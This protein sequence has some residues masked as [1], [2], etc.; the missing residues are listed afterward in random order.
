MEYQVTCVCGNKFKVE[1]GDVGKHVACPACNRALIPVAAVAVGGAEGAAGAAAAAGAVAP[2]SA[3]AMEHTAMKRCPFCGEPILAIA[4][5][6]RYCK[7][8][9]DRGA[10]GAASGGEAAAGG[11]AGAGEEAAAVFELSVSQW[12]NFF[13]YVICVVVVAMVGGG[14]FGL[15]RMGWNVA[16][17]YAVAIFSG[18]VLLAGM[19]AFSFYLAARNSRCTIRPNRI[20]TEVGTFN[21][22]TDSIEMFRVTDVELKQ[23]FIERLLGIGTVRIR[24]N[25]PT[26]PML[27][28]YE[29]PQARK[30]YKYVQEQGPKA[31]LQRNTLHIQP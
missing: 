21:K 29:I 4:R 9:L 12:D 18:V 2:A 25:D 3:A 8:Y 24:S 30:V 15:H 28:L 19:T 17:P 1:D 23:S 5:K 6:C 7:E 31:D 22:Q 11:K 26:T 13:R 20:E 14:L 10:P 16:E 27:E